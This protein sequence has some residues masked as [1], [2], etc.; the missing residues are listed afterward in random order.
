MKYSRDV[1]QTKINPEIGRA[2]QG[3]RSGERVSRAA[4]SICWCRIINRNYQ[5]FLL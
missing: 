2:F 3:E 5:S 4:R 1:T